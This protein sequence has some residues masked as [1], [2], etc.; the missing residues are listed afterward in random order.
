MGLKT[1]SPRKSQSSI[2]SA[3]KKNGW[4]GAAMYDPLA[5]SVVI[6]PTLVTLKDMH[7]DYWN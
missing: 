4:D 7:V 1:M 6:D 3:P 5:V 2:S